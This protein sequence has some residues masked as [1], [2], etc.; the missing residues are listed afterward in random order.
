V[1]TDRDALV[2][3]LRQL[4][5][6]GIEEIFLDSLTSAE[7]LALLAGR[8]G[9]AQATAPRDARTAAARPTG[10]AASVGTAVSAGTAGGR[11]AF[12]AVA[13]GLV[14]RSHVSPGNAAPV[15]SRAHPDAPAPADAAAAAAAAAPA[16]AAAREVLR[17]G[18][19]PVAAV[20]ATCTR[21]RLHAERTTVVFGE[22]NPAADVVVVGEA[23]GQE[24]DRTGRPF[25]GRAGKLLDLLLMSV[26]FPRDSVYICNTL[27][28][29]PPNNRNPLPDEVEACS[30]FLRGQLEAISPKVLLAVGKFAAHAL[31]Q[32]EES[33]GRLRGSVHQYR[34]SPLIVTYHPAYLLRS[35]QMTR[36][37]WQDFQLLRRVLDEQA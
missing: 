14:E 16:D 19:D 11:A 15:G 33:I 12:A 31:L 9:A 26:G 10:T 25:V 28:C 1:S 34:G 30:A 5:E 2:R 6:L 24:E 27:K 37:A 29:R 3:Y 13:A 18:L 23:P 8:A 32:T 36:I 35:P 7:A 20:A 21:C 4:A 17:A 22:G